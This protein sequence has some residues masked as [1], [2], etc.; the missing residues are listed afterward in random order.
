[1][2][3][4]DIHTLVQGFTNQITLLVNQ[5]ALESVRAALVGDGLS[6][7]RRGRQHGRAR[8]VAGLRR[9]GRPSKT[10]PAQ[11]QAMADRLYAHVKA[12][13][14]ERATQIAAAL[15]TNPD[16][17]RPAMQQLVAAKRVTTKGQRRG[18][19]YFAG[20]GGASPRKRA[21]AKKA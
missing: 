19:T 3:Q 12:N 1:M 14:G 18:M 17:M 20:A 7:T 13:P 9:R 5:A 6:T 8:A 21:R 10:S 11:Q 2:P 15:R 4:T 16:A